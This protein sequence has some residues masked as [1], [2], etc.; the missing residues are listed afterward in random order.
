MVQVIAEKSY[1][2]HER[3]PRDE[4]VDGGLILQCGVHAMR[5]V[6]HVAGA[7]VRWKPWRAISRETAGCG[8]RPT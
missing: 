7:C 6:E 4:D 3:R 5:F 1:P 2:Y 8:W